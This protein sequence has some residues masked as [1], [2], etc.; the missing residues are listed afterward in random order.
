MW[1][2]PKIAAGTNPVTL[3]EAKRQVRAE[4]FS[5]DDAYLETLLAA[6]LDHAEKYCGAQ[7]ALRHFEVQATAWGDLCRLPLTPVAD[8]VLN[9]VDLG[10]NVAAV[11]TGVYDLR[12]AAIVLKPGNSWPAAQYGS[13]ITLTGNT[14]FAE[15]PPAV[16]HAMLLW[17]DE[18]YGNRASAELAEWTA[19]DALLCNHRYYS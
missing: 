2:I 8:P 16:K 5:D 1:L 4:D 14:G 11:D 3:Q 9:Y 13:L 15:C 18:A 19:L 7:F 10:G 12:D 17:L 6:A